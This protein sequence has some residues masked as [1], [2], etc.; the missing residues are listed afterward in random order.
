MLT[1]MMHDFWFEPHPSLHP[2]QGMEDSRSL[3]IQAC[4]PGEPVARRRE[5]QMQKEVGA[6]GR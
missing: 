5:E 4:S 2:L 1:K 6:V 3:R